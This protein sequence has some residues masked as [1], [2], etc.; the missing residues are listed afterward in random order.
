MRRV[1]SSRPT[2]LRALGA[3]AVAYAEANGRFPDSAPLT[4]SAPPRG[5]R[6]R[7]T[8]NVGRP[9][10]EGSRVPARARGRAARLRVRVRVRRGTPSSRARGAISTATASSARSRSAA[11]SRPA[12]RRASS[13]ACTWRPSSNEAVPRDGCSR[14][15]RAIAV[16]VAAIAVVQPQ[17][18]ACVKQTEARRRLTAIPPPAAASRDV[19]RL[20]TP[21]SPICSGRSCSSSMASIRKRSAPSP[22]C[23]AY[24]DA[25]IALEPDHPTHLP[26]RRH[27]VLFGP[28]GGDDRT[29]RLARRRISSEATNERPYDHGLWLHYGQFIAFLAPS[30]LKDE[31][32]IDGGGKTVPSPSPTPSSSEPIPIARLAASTILSEE[33]RRREVAIKQLQ[34]AYRAH[35]T[36]PRR[37]ARSSSSSSAGG[38]AEAEDGRRHR[39]TRMAHALPIPVARTQRSSSARVADRRAVRG[40]R[41]SHIA[42]SA[43]ATGRARRSD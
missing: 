20:S 15:P 10:L 30:F 6:K 14:W 17:L 19:A 23:R 24:I 38:R 42:R 43:R 36:I 35:A 16:C 41:S 7:P 2:D 5:R 4:P 34:R 11:S 32:E 33:R 37:A 28:T 25:I 26:V 18:A 8:G 1:S 39:R 12:R 40:P 21:R 9:H 27:A 22:S 13:P 29:T 3:A 31:A